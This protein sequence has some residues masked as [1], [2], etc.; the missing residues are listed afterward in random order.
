[1]Y[2]VYVA[3]KFMKTERRMVEYLL[4]CSGLTIQL[5][6]A[7]CGKNGRVER[8]KGRREGKKER[9]WRRKNEQLPSTVIELKVMPNEKVLEI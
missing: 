2:K 7:P 4:W 1:M 5:Q 3:A 6:V 9:D 8:R